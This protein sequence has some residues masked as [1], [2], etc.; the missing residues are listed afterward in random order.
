MT[1]QFLASVRRNQKQWMVVVTILA[2]FAFLFDGA[3]QSANNMTPGTWAIFFAV[4]CAAGMSIIGYSRGHTV[5]FATIGFIVGGSAA[6]I[7]TTFAGPRPIVR[8]SVGNLTLEQ[9]RQLQNQRVKI[10]RFLNIAASKLGDSAQVPN[11]GTPDEA[12]MVSFSILTQEARRMGVSVSDEAVNNFLKNATQG[13]LTQKDY[14][15]AL[16]EA[17]YSESELFDAIRH[18][19]EAQL[20]GRLMTPPATEDRMLSLFSNGQLGRVAQVSPEMAW[21]NFRRL[22]V[23][24]ELTAVAI[25]V[26]DFVKQVPEPSDTEILKYFD[27][28][29][30]RYGDD[31]GNPGFLEQ[32]KVKLGYLAAS[33][34]DLYE[35]GLTDATDQEVVDYYNSHLEEYR[36]Q[37]FPDSSPLNGGNPPPLDGG[38]QSI[39]PDAPSDAMIPENRSVELPAPGIEAPAEPKPSEKTEP[40]KKDAGTPEK[41]DSD[42]PKGEEK[43]KEEAKGEENAKGE[44]PCGDD[45]PEAKEEKS[46]AKP[47]DSKGAEAVD[48]AKTEAKPDEKADNREITPPAPALPTGDETLPKLEPPTA[49]PVLPPGEF[50]PLVPKYRALDD[51]LKLEIREKLLRD[52]AFAKMSAA[53]DKAFQFMMDLSLNLPTNAEERAEAIKPLAEKCKAYAAENGLE[54]HET[55]AMT[56]DE[57]RNSM[58]DR[59]GSATESVSEQS[60]RRA[61]RTVAEIVFEPDQSAR[62]YRVSLYSPQRADSPKMRYAYWTIEQIPAKVP[63]LKNDVTR[64]LVIEAWK[65][66]KARVLAEAR[67]RELTE[68]VK[69]SPTDIPAALSGQTINGTKESPAVTVRESSRFSWL[70]TSQTVPSMGLPRP[71]VSEIDNVEHPGAEFMKLI[72]EQLGEGDV[73]MGLNQPKTVF[74]VVRAHDRDG[75]GPDGGVTLQRLQ[76]QFLKERAV[77]EVP[78]GGF[79]FPT[80]SDFLSAQI[81]NILDGLWRQSFEKRF[82]ITWENVE[83]QGAEADS[84]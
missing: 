11:F 51:D 25:P 41:K 29:K 72:F 34:L 7:G 48:E 37:Q 33:D 42:T 2:I 14:F 38:V 3:V 79:S 68:L 30:N 18:E 70:R 69:K 57:L 59:I 40:E 58:D 21:E 15:E 39:D 19:L 10:H 56:F 27:E 80:A 13:K 74:Y 78:K 16:K 71:E 4:L 60:A 73:G 17:E 6:L 35:K 22:N 62:S 44:A 50:S 81:Q 66:E 67:A 8:T 53:A 31:R 55:K 82:A 45:E 54:Y 63:D 36:I 1:M 46:D 9:I 83:P 77:A 64:N 76:E 47:A 23:R 26:S 32:P 61:L 75:A 65:F 49:G 12:A 84:K 20:V 5:I 28:R 24:Q 43:P 52:K